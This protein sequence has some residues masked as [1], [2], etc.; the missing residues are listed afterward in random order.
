[1]NKMPSDNNSE[2]P[3]DNNSELPE[4]IELPEIELNPHKS[5]QTPVH[6]FEFLGI[7]VVSCNTNQSQSDSKIRQRA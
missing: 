1:M 3:Y 2:L 7:T 6:V 4:L 5:T